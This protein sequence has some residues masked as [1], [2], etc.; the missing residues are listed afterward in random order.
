LS[1]DAE[2]RWITV[3]HHASVTLKFSRPPR[4]G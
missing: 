1:A 3:V 2:C 4:R